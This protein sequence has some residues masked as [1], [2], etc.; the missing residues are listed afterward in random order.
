MGLSYSLTPERI[1]IENGSSI[2]ANGILV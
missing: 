1:F 2:E